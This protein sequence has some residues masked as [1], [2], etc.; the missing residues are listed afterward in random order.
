MCS[1]TIFETSATLAHYWN[2]KIEPLLGIGTPLS[3][4]NLTAEGKNVS[5]SW[6]SLTNNHVLTLVFL[7]CRI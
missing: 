1:I 4:A 3:V 7:T 6:H 5:Y 2:A